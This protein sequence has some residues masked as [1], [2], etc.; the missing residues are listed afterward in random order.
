MQVSQDCD[1]EH[2]LTNFNCTEQPPIKTILRLF[3]VPDCAGRA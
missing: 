2:V 1:C 3:T